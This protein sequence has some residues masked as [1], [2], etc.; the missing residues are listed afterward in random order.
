M[1]LYDIPRGTRLIIPIKKGRKYDMVP[2]TFRRI[3]G[4]S[5]YSVANDGSIIHLAA[6]TEVQLIDS[7]Y[8]VK[9]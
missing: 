1:K 6:D 4:P 7:V 2:C 3:E 9:P 8:H 5:S